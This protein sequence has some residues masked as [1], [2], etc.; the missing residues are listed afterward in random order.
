MFWGAGFDILYSCQDHE[1]DVANGLFSV[2]SAFGIRNAL[3]ISRLFHLIA[4]ACFVRMILTFDLGWIAALGVLVT[5]AALFYE[6]TL[7]SADD[8]SKINAAFFTTNGFISMLILLAVTAD[9]LLA[10][11]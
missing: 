7:V 2:P 9:R 5:G 6:H 8:L 1:Y 11:N 3:L 10:R 4:F